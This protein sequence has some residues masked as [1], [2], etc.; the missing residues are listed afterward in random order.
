MLA[1]CNTPEA[2][3]RNFKRL[4]IASDFLTPADTIAFSGF[5]KSHHIR[6]IIKNMS[7]DSILAHFQNRG[8][9]TEFDM[10]FMSNL[11]DL[12]QLS[13]SNVLHRI[14]DRDLVEN[15]TF[16]SWDK[17][18]M[19]L[20][21]D[22]YVITD[23]NEMRDFQYSELSHGRK[24]TTDLTPKEMATFKASIFS[25]YGK[26]KEKTTRWITK[27][28]SQIIELNDSIKQND[29][30]F[31]QPFR[32]TRLSHIDLEKDTYIFPSQSQK[33]GAFADGVGVGIIR[34]ASKYSLGIEFMNYYKNAI[35]NQ[36]LCNQLQLLPTSNPNRTSKYVYQNNYPILYR[37]N[38][39]EIALL[40]GQFETMQQKISPIN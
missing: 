31:Q 5:K 16:F 14:N 30:L 10:V 15:P 12:D 8:Y 22:P 25:Q 32:L 29:S 11:Y 19:I 33:F 18:W 38:L 1:S 7:Y 6:I 21:I 20:G 26:T 17:Q 23:L 2:P 3:T 39:N 36:N 35:F 34:H 4:T 9:N 37:V 28:E 27:M 13:K 40:F 24:W